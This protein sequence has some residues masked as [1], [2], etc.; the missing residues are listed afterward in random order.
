MLWYDGRLSQYL[1]LCAINLQNLQPRSQALSS[2][3]P[4][5]GDER[6]WEWGCKI[7]SFHL[8]YHYMACRQHYQLTVLCTFH[9]RVECYDPLKDEWKFVASM[10]NCRDGA[11]VVTDGRLIYAISGY[12]GSNYL[13]SVEVYD[14]VKDKWNI[15]GTERI[16]YNNLKFWQHKTFIKY[17]W[18]R[19]T[20]RDSTNHPSIW[21][22]STI[23]PFHSQ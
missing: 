20:L 5:P 12:D 7:F 1:P 15:G 4:R 23:Q 6:A 8:L 21:L 10:N 3:G 11:C 14:P 18:Q 16:L 2:P 13:S 17:H 9:R 22:H 19:K